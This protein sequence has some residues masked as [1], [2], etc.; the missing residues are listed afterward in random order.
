MT[1]PICRNK[2][3][4]FENLLFHGRNELKN[5]FCHILW[6]TRGDGSKCNAKVQILH[7]GG[8]GSTGVL[9]PE[10]T[11]DTENDRRENWEIRANCEVPDKSIAR[12]ESS[13]S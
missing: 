13:Y 5:R 8:S 2:K 11:G 3:R 1:L 12:E 9:V 7:F 4:F 10:P 6:K